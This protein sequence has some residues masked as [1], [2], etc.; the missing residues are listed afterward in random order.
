MKAIHFIHN[1]GKFALAAGLLTATQPLFAQQTSS[2]DDAKAEKNTPDGLNT[3]VVTAQRREEKLQDVPIQIAAFSEEA[4][5]DADIS[6]TQDFVNLVPNVSLDDSF[7]YL[8][9]FIVVRGVTQIN[10]ADSPVAVIVDGVPQNNQ[11]QLK[12]N[13]FDVERI[14]VLKGPQGGLYGR[15][16]IGGAINIVTKAPSDVFEG[17]VSASYGRGDDLDFTGAIS[18]PIGDKAAL[19]LSGNYK[20]SDGLIRNKFTNE[21]VDGIDHDWELRGRF[22]ADLSDNFSADLR[23]SYRDFRAG[24]IYDSQVISKDANDYQRPSSNI[25]GVTYGDIFDASLKLDMELG[26][27]TLS[28]ITAY[29]DI[30]ENYRGDLDFSNE[31]DTPGGFLGLGIQAGQGQ[32]LGVELTSQEIRLVSDQNSALRWILG[33]YYLHTKRDLLTRAFI[34]LDSSIDQIDNDGLVILRLQES[35]KNDAFAVYANLDYDLTDKLTFSAALRYDHDKRKQLDVISGNDRQTSFD[36]IQPKATLTYKIDP[37]HL[38]YATYSKGFRSGGYNAPTVVIPVF[39]SEKLE[40]YEAGFK[41]SWL[42]NHLIVNG[43]AYFA[44]SKDFQFFFIDVATASQIIGN[45]DKVHIWG[46]E[47]EVQAK[48][49]DAFQLFA[50]L[51]TTDTNIRR[52]A[53]DPASIGNKTPKSTDWSLNLGAQYKAPIFAD[54]DLLLRADYEHRGDKYWQVDNV[55]VQKPVDLV[56]VRVG[57]ENDRWGFYFSGKNIFNEKYYADYNPTRYSGGAEDIGFLSKPATWQF[58]LKFNY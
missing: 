3:I 27:V 26:G 8:N 9:S 11:K 48:L 51:G 46:V 31:V 22:D 23:T 17:S 32:D 42:N 4:I 30:H 45:I 33:G 21:K 15:N 6:A 38:V 53:L 34:D 24:A 35:N 2:P 50:G 14:E 25:L 52:N 18:T 29:S 28:S 5:S 49:N 54:Y 39:K 58:E 43:A 56:N 44:E 41:T 12:M 19:R 36:N 37:E 20:E 10:N 57:V 1:A 16:A 13:L 55:D 7:T 40:N 47:L